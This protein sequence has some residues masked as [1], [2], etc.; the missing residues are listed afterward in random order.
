MRVVMNRKSLKS[1]LA[2]LAILAACHGSAYAA[3]APQ[4]APV[5]IEADSSGWTFAFSP[6]FWAAGLS[7]DISQF[8]LPTVHVNSDFGDIL[9][10]LDFAAMA[11]GEARNGTYSFFGD[12]MYTKLSSGTAT[13]RGIVANTVD[14]TS[15]TFAGLFGAG[16]SVFSDDRGYLDIVAAA[17]VWHV[18]TEISFSGGILNGVDVDDSATWIDGLAG[19]RGRYALTDKFYLMGWGLVGAGQADIDWDVAAGLGYNFNDSIS[20]IAG[21]RALGVNYEEDDFLF[22]TVQQGPILGLVIRF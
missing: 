4:S 13:P 12:V 17:R 14:V 20:A 2:S 19:I 11:V 22:D 7:G 18:S 15:E 5:P 3:D 8:G 1:A 9:S 21:Y 16:Y 10:N 6:Y